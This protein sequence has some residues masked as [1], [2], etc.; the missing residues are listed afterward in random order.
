MSRP[1]TAAES[2][3]ARRSNNDAY[4]DPAEADQSDYVPPGGLFLVGYLD[5][6]A[7]A[8]GGYRAYDRISRTVEIKKMY[9]LPTVRGRGYGYAIIRELERHA[10]A[11]GARRAILETGVRNTGALALY[12]G[13][14]YR[15]IDSY[16][17]GRQRSATIDAW[18]CATT[19]A[20]TPPARCRPATRSSVVASPVISCS[21]APVRPEIEYTTPRPLT[22]ASAARW[23]ISG[24]VAAASSLLTVTRTSCE[25]ARAKATT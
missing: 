23:A 11:A 14:G 12:I 1:A 5:G 6:E 25:P 17:D 15:P 10:A 2:H 9:T 20:I 16:V 13:V 21:T 3:R 22:P 19:V 8:C 4:A 18:P 24:T 7:V